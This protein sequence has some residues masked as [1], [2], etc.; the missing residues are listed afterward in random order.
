MTD[1]ARKSAELFESGFY[2]AESVL[3]AFAEARGI[4]SDLLP[5]IAT[6]FCSGVSRTCGMC[7]AA[8][9]AIMALGL[10][11]GRRAPTEA[12]DPLYQSVQTLLAQFEARFGSTNCQTL[13]GCD[14]NTEA[15]QRH[16]VA[17]GQFTRC[18]GYVEA[19][20]RLALAL[21]D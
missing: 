9:G 7:G 3:L 8:S 15:G 18:R 17:S 20:T 5:A 1:P 11:Q 6:G 13:C 16:F 14:L 21:T 2:C 10:V 19:A 12:V 4:Q